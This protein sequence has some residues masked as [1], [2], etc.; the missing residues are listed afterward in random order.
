MQFEWEIAKQRVQGARLDR[1]RAIDLWD[2]S[3]AMLIWGGDK[4]KQNGIWVCGTRKLDVL[5]LQSLICHEALHNFVRR[6]R[7]G[8]VWLAEETEH[9]AMALLGDPQLQPGLAQ[10]E[11][12]ELP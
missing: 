3:L 10:T 1:R 5:A 9:I 12:A 11:F 2:D 6:L 4:E 7:P 8:Y